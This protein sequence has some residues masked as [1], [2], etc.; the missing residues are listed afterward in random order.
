MKTKLLLT[1]GLF[2][3]VGTVEAGDKF[4]AGLKPKP[5]C[6]LFGQTLSWPIPSLCVGAKAGVT[7]DVDVSPQGLKLKIPY[8]SLEIPFPTLS[9]VTK[10]NR[11]DLKL[12]EVTK[13]K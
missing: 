2:L 10:T 7:P 5:H 6:T 4:S 12:G 8:L 9:I 11:I 1:I 13:Y 3:Y